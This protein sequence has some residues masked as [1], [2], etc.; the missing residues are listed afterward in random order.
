MIVGCSLCWQNTFLG[1]DPSNIVDN[2][3]IWK[4][5]E[6]L[7]YEKR[8]IA[9]K[10]TLVDKEDKISSEDS[11]FNENSTKNLHINEN[12]CIKDKTNEYIDTV[13]KSIYK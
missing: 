10:V 4:N 12:S 7:F 6:P 2:K 3:T 8:K 1:V 11:S 9:D 5:I 13:E